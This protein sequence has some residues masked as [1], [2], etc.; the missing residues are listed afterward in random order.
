MNAHIVGTSLFLPGNLRSLEDLGAALYG[1]DGRERPTV[2]EDAELRTDFTRFRIAPRQAK[3]ID[4][5][6]LLVLDCA[7]RALADAGLDQQDLAG[8]QTGVF[9]GMTESDFVHTID[10]DGV[11]ESNRSYLGV[12]NNRG[13]A[14][15]RVSY[16]FDLR[17][18]SW[19]VD[20]TCSSG[21]VALRHGITAIA[22]GEVDLA[23]VVASHLVR[24]EFGKLV[25]TASG[26]ISQS[27]RCHAF[28]ERADGFT[29][30]EGVVAVVLAPDGA[31]PRALGRVVCAV[32]HDGRT[33]GLT[34]PNGGAQ[35]DVVERALRMSGLSSGD[36]DY[37]EA[38][39]TG[40]PLGDPIEVA[41]LAAAYRTAERAAPLLIGSNKPRFGHLEAA[42]G[43]LSL[44]VAV[45]ALR[46]QRPPGLPGEG[47]PS[48]R[49][50]WAE[51]NIRPALGEFDWPESIT[52]A[53]VS[54][55]GLSGTNAHA[56]VS[57]IT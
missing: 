4:P 40:T 32:N 12:G 25:R 41:A 15:G 24:S 39:G 14:A 45:Q 8:S 7:E 43:L 27:A 30:G 46:R 22:S 51:H 28:D 29:V 55:F 23:I 6:H 11:A 13:A 16:T 34:V 21:L 42:S 3:V 38:H 37:V 17:G 54:A 44:L 31:G 2:F 49:I 19:Q 53:G 56:I 5:Q 9:V 50:P 18:P 33:A 26:A 47:L 36:V 57:S 35:R 48:G 10:V 20:T 1:D 52:S